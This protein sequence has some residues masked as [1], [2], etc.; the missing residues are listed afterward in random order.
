MSKHHY[1]AHSPLLSYHGAGGGAH[2]SSHPH[3]YP[4]EAHSHYQ[5]VIII[6]KKK[7]KIFSINKVFCL[8]FQ[9]LEP[10]CGDH[11]SHSLDLVTTLRSE[12]AASNYKRDRLINEVHLFG[13]IFAKTFAIN[14]YLISYRYLNSRAHYVQKMW[15]VNNCEPKLHVNPH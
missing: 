2:H 9:P 5:H 6:I 3:H 8:L 4:P 1:P 7:L 14:P 12:L 10:A 13:L 11:V 15:K